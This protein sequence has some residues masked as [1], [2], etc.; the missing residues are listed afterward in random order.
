MAVAIKAIN[1]S[2]LNRAGHGRLKAEIEAL[3][4]LNHPAVAQLF[5]VC[6]QDNWVY[7]IMEYGSRGTLQHCIPAGGMS[8]EAA[9]D[10]FRQI[11]AGL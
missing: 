10:L 1:T 6:T 7:I 5:Q 8:E 11:L 2:L 3:K 9:R 4:R